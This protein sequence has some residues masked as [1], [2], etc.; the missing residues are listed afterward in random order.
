M[1]NDTESKK[2]KHIERRR[3]HGLSYREL[4]KEF[5]MSKSAVHR[6]L[7]PKPDTVPDDKRKD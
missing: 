4:A 6:K 1:N 3:S 5:D 7:T 2:K